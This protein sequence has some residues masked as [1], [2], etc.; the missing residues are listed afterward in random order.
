MDTD[1]QGLIE[2][3]SC[4]IGVKVLYSGERGGRELIRLGSCSKDISIF[5]TRILKTRAL[6]RAIA[7]EIEKGRG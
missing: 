4:A 5:Q 6:V 1:G 2:T 3:A 7:L